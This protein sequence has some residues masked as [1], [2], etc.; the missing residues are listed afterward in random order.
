VRLYRG[1]V[2][3]PEPYSDEH[4]GMLCRSH[5]LSLPPPGCLFAVAVRRAHPGLF[6]PEG[7]GG[8]L[9]LCVVGRPVARCL[10]Q[11]GTVGEVTRLVLIGGLPYA[12]AS[13]LLMRSAEVARSR[14]VS[15][16]IAYHDRTRHTGCIYRKAGFRKDKSTRARS[17]GWGSRPGRESAKQNGTPK[18]RWRLDLV[19]SP[20]EA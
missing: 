15:C 13:A 3:D 10:P 12:T 18:R 17:S 2:M 5:Y 9:G 14:G 6:G 7:C 20:E 8:L 1:L 4:K 11:D 16:L 19:P